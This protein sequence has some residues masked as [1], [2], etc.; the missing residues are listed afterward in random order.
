MQGKTILKLKNRN[1]IVYDLEIKKTIEE[2]G[3]WGAHDRMGISVA[4]AYDFREMRFRVFLEDNMKE[5]VERLNEPETL[6]SGFNICDFDNKVLRGSG[7]PLKPDSELLIYDML[8]ESRMGALGKQRA[9]KGG[10]KLDDHLRV[11][12][13]PM[14]TAN[15]ALAPIWYKEGKIGKVI[16]YCIADVHAELSL[17]RYIWDQGTLACEY[18]KT[19]YKVK[20]PQ[21]LFKME[22]PKTETYLESGQSDQGCSEEKNGPET[23]L[24]GSAVL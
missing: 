22:S 7:Y 24:T 2:A 16:D 9:I 11:M 1:I 10:F 13:L 18:M 8:L 15:G 4:C 6:I 21:E 14:K 23:A 3:G 19:P 5:F 12:G 20:R 17:F